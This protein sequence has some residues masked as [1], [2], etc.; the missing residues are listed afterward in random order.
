[1]SRSL[2]DSEKSRLRGIFI[3]VVMV[4]T[5]LLL[6]GWLF[7]HYL[8]PYTLIDV[9]LH[10]EELQDTRLKEIVVESAGRAAAQTPVTCIIF[11]VPILVPGSGGLLILCRA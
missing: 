1:M 8:T 10:G 2:S 6:Y 4:G 5:A 3:A 11:A 7:P 9:V